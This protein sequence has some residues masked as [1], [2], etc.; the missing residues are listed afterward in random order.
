MKV[1][2]E[3]QKTTLRINKAEFSE[4]IKVGML[5]DSFALPGGENVELYVSLNDQKQYYYEKNQFHLKLPEKKI[6]AYIPSKI[7]LSFYFQLDN[8]DQHHLLFEVDIKKKPLK[9]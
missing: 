8:K 9:K 2:L 6:L 7:G 3:P 4:L 5:F 1:R